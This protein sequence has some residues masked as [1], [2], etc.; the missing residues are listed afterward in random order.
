MVD[1]ASSGCDDSIEE[2]GI[3]YEKYRKLYYEA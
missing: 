2:K 1:Q 3:L